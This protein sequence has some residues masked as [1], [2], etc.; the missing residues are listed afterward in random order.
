MSLDDCKGILQDEM[1][2]CSK[3]RD[4]KPCGCED[5]DYDFTPIKKTL[6]DAMKKLH[7]LL[8]P[9][10]VKVCEVCGIGSTATEVLMN[11]SNCYNCNSPLN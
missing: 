1:G 5:E 7:A 8:P 9:E 6:G 10:M 3:C 2:I 11:D 4:H